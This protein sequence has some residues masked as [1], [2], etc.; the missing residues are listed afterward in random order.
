MISPCEGKKV[1]KIS[2][3][4]ERKVEKIYPREKRKVET[5]SP[6]R[7]K[8]GMISPAGRN[9]HRIRTLDGPWLMLGQQQPKR[10]VGPTRAHNEEKMGQ[11]HYFSTP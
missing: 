11:A 6:P 7:G 3:H 1:E 4:E 9:Y 8:L 2:L 5:I 10:L